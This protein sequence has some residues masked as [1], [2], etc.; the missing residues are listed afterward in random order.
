MGVLDTN[1]LTI[2]YR[3]PGRTVAVERN[4][5]H[6]PYSRLVYQPIGRQRHCLQVK[7]VADHEF[8]A[9]S[10]VRKQALRALDDGVEH[11]LIGGRRTADHPQDVAGGGLLPQG[12][13]QFAGAVI[14]LALKACIGLLEIGGHGVELVGQRFELVAGTHHDLLVQVAGTDLRRAGLQRADRLHHAPR[15]EH[16]GEHRQEQGG[17]Q[18]AERAVEGFKQR[19]EGLLA[20]YFDHHQPVER[21]NARER[22]QHGFAVAVDRL[23]VPGLGFRAGVARGH[24][25]R[26]PG[27]VELLQHQAD[28]GMRHQMAFG[29]DHVGDT[30][31]ADTQLRHH[32]PD[33]LEIDLDRGGTAVATA[34][35]AGDGHVGFGVLAKGDRAEP[36]GAALGADHPRVARQV[37][38]RAHR[39]H[40]QARHPYLLVAGTV[41]PGGF[42]DLRRLAQ[43]LEE[44]DAALVH[45][46]AAFGHARQGG[47]ADFVF[48]LANVLFDAVGGGVGLLA[49][50]GE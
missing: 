8:Q 30:G 13:A 11:R 45:H 31:A 27:P 21:G 28:V 18:H 25:L 42:G 33:E 38:G 10:F 17:E 2:Q 19:L 23:D 32:V 7:L 5:V 6:A 24:H 49:L 34:G 46:V 48:D 50:Q 14:D 16:A 15:Q 39:I 43:Q 3:A 44:L 26:L 37:G 35:R 47:P 1:D 9:E 20:R 29:I 4:R 40:R 12:F 22:H 36:G 41:D